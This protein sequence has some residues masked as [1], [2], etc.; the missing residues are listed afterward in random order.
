MVAMGW[1]LPGRIRSA[2]P[3]TRRNDV[4]VIMTLRLTGDPKALEQMA[5][6]DPERLARIIV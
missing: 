3:R 4:S 1:S 5:H 2:G 6:G